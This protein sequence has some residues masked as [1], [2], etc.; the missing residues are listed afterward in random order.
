M[1]EHLDETTAAQLLAGELPID[2]AEAAHRHVARCRDCESFLA[3]LA[4]VEISASMTRE[5]KPAVD[6]ELR[7]G[8]IVGRFLVL[9]RLGAGGMGVVYAAYDPELDRRVALKLL[10]GSSREGDVRA[11]LLREA[12]AAA[13]LSHPNVVSVF[14]IGVFEERVYFAMEYVEGVTLAEWLRGERSWQDVVKMFV[15]AGRGIAAAHEVGVIHRDFKPENVLVG[16]DGRA[17]VVDFG[18]ARAADGE[19]TPP[20]VLATNADPDETQ[21]AIRGISDRLTRTG[22]LLGTPRFMAPEQFSGG[23]ITPSTDQ[24][25]FCVALYAALYRTLPFRGDKVTE[26]ASSVLA[27]EIAPPVATPGPVALRR[28][29]VRGLSVDPSR[30]HASMA[31][32]LRELERASS[33][34]RRRIVV[35]GAAAAAILVAGGTLLASSARDAAPGPCLDAARKVRSV[36]NADREARVRS[37]FEARQLSFGE[38]A[39]RGVSDRLGTYANAWAAMRT[40]ACEATH[41]HHEQSEQLLDLRTVCLDDRLAEL[42]ALVLAFESADADTVSRS[43]D[44]ADRLPSLGPCADRAALAAAIRPPDATIASRVDAVA[45]ELATVATLERLGKLAPALA[46]AEHA[47]AAADAIKYPPLTARCRLVVGRLVEDATGNHRRAIELLADSVTQGLAGNDRNRTAEA[48]LSLAKTLFAGAGPYEEAERWAK[49]ADGAAT[50]L[51]DR[52]E[53]DGQL[54][55][56]RGLIAMRRGRFAD[57][58]PQFERLLAVR[59]RLDPRGGLPVANAHVFLGHALAALGRIDDAESHYKHALAVIEEVSG[60]AHPNL[61]PVL[62]GLGQ[63]AFS[64]N[65]PK[66]AL[67]HL[68]RALAITRSTVPPGHPSLIN[69]LA[70]FGATLSNAG[71]LDRALAVLEEARTTVAPTDRRELALVLSNL[72]AVYQQ[73]GDPAKALATAEQAL[74]VEREVKGETHIETALA[75]YNV[76]DTLLSNDRPRDAVDSI[77]KAI[78]IWD[79]QLPPDHPY[80]DAGHIAIGDALLRAGDPRSAIAPLELAVAAGKGAGPRTKFFLARALWESNADRKRGVAVAKQV[81]AALPR[82]DAK[83]R[84]EIERWL[85]GR[86]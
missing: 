8:T 32:L 31:A 39:A 14:D 22:A 80:L 63:V 67:P 56:V 13:R 54:A 20:P 12:Q 76:G 11:R 49:L 82:E 64:R 72:V 17:R 66:D 77:R 75:H 48:A 83:L 70:N 57:A 69:A 3:E 18:L 36:W 86:Q 78:A 24:F 35:A 61:N 79:Q 55:A 58:L 33:Q 34:R 6:G 19:A 28:A 4:R 47:C 38:L 37:A 43:I 40:D 52:G 5:S 44:A 73:K 65:R 68:E 23:E 85:I 62:D 71:E 26:L 42:A 2:E 21:P 60:R 84:S 7:R 30:R 74:V 25:G 59:G 9:G 45:G 15:Q 41:V 1:T 51:S 29:I 50:Q 81:L 27:G 46:A 10:R 16:R 53:V